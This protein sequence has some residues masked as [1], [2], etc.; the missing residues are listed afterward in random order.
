MVADALTHVLPTDDA[1]R[2][3]LA[4]SMG[5]PDWVTF[6]TVLNR[7]RQKVQNSL[8]SCSVR[9]RARPRPPKLHRWRRCGSTL[10][11]KS[12][13]NCYAL[14][15]T[16]SR[17][18]CSR[19]CAACARARPTARC[20]PRAARVS[21]GWCRCCYRRRHSRV[22]GETLARL[23][24]LLEAIGRRA[25]YLALLVENP[26]ALSQLV[27][28][29]AASPWI[30]GWIASHLIVL[31]ELLDP[32]MLYTAVYA[33][34]FNRGVARAAGGSGRGRRRIADGV[35][36]RVSTISHLLR[37]TATDLGPGLPPELVGAHLADIA[38]VVIGESLALAR[39]ALV[40]RHGQP[41]CLRDGSVLFARLRRHRLRQTRRARARLCLG[42]GH[43]LSI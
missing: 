14:P 43:D 1:E 13:R 42:P 3:R 35:V 31:D 33:R 7:H 36:T 12:L 6:E 41:T 5:F 20:R 26:M 19:C 28:L 2:Q 16:A 24:R 34:G 10:M 38:E 23:V 11:M 18:A 30:A 40:Q 17:K 37:I 27:K 15:V 32:R 29:C 22:P 39:A 21:T 9:L 4:F 8:R 25:S